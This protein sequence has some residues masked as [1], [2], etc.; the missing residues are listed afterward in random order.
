MKFNFITYGVA[1]LF[2]VIS[3]MTDNSFLFSMMWL[4]LMVRSIYA[5]SQ[6][7]TYNTRYPLIS[8]IA[9]NLLIV[10]CFWLGCFYLLI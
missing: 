6:I 3:I 10:L 8:E 2:A 9:D 4:V 5:I 1:F 7:E